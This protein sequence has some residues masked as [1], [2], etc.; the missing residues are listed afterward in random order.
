MSTTN[1]K[2][3]HMTPSTCVTHFVELFL[4]MC[5]R[6][7]IS[8]AELELISLELH[9]LHRQFPDRAF[10]YTGISFPRR[11]HIPA[12]NATHHGAKNMTKC[13]SVNT[14]SI[15][16]FSPYKYFSLST[17]TSSSEER[18]GI[19]NASSAVAATIKFI[20]VATGLVQQKVTKYFVKLNIDCSTYQKR[21]Y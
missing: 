14:L 17:L 16:S 8:R 1:D 2:R 15:N 6:R 5:D 4:S 19:D 18:T 7:S 11:P 9:G 13:G 21:V 12:T 20:F 3:H 10:L